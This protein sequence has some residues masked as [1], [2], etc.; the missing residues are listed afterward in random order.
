MRLC[1][2]ATPDSE[3]IRLDKWLW[4]ARWYKTRNLA[5]QAIESGKVS[6]NGAR[7]KTSKEVA[8][9]A[10]LSIRQ[11][12]DERTVVILA[13]S[14]QRRGAPEAQSL[15]QESGESIKKRSENALLRKLMN[16]ELI[17]PETKPS[18][19]DRRLIHQFK[20]KNRE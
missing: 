5:K 13:L 6:Y 2:M 7:C 10:E 20:Q 12:L 8:V 9:G 11:G 17:A 3:R 1:Q 18:K 15:Y 16:Q 14:G 19:K 4:A